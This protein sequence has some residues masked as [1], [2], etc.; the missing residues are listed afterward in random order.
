MLTWP[1]AL[2]ARG[3]FVRANLSRRAGAETRES[4]GTPQNLRIKMRI[5]SPRTPTATKD[6]IALTRALFYTCGLAGP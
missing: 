2:V 1:T 5:T 6:P 3:A 4:P